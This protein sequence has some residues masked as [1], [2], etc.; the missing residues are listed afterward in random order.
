[1]NRGFAW[2]REIIHDC[3][4]WQNLWLDSEVVTSGKSFMT[5]ADDFKLFG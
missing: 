2:A 5:F 4:H 1:M 3:K